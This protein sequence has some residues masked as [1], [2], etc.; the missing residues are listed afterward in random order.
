MKKMKNVI[1]PTI[2]GLLLKYIERLYLPKK[3]QAIFNLSFACFE[4]S[5]FRN[6]VIGLKVGSVRLY[7][8]FSLLVLYIVIDSA[9]SLT[10][11]YHVDFSINLYNS[12]G[13]S[14]PYYQKGK[15]NFMKKEILTPSFDFSSSFEH[16]LTMVLSHDKEK[17]ISPDHLR[18]VVLLYTLVR[19]LGYVTDTFEHDYESL[20]TFLNVVEGKLHLHKRKGFVN[21]ELMESNEVFNI[22]RSLFISK[23][24]IFRDF[25]EGP[26]IYFELE[27]FHNCI[28]LLLILELELFIKRLDNEIELI[29]DE[30]KM[31]KVMARK[32]I[33]KNR[34]GKLLSM[35]SPGVR[36][37]LSKKRVRIQSSLFLGFDTEFK[38]RN[39]SF[40]ELLAYSTAS[41]VRTSLEI[42]DFMVNYVTTNSKY[43]NRS[44]L[45]NKE[46]ESLILI[47]R[48]IRGREDFKVPQLISNLKEKGVSYKKLQGKLVFN[49][50]N[51][52][53]EDIKT[54]FKDLRNAEYK[55]AEMLDNSIGAQ[56]VEMLGEI[57]FFHDILSLS[58]FS[59]RQFLVKR[60]CFLIAHFNVADIASALD[61]E[62]FK[63]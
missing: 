7:S 2:R 47:I 48:F 60:E 29:N 46:M 42:S 63:P 32:I 5:N 11:D 40:N 27:H 35:V 38:V 26:D 37:C 31:E 17:M 18:R 36:S 54:L 59:K 22:F 8:I 53:I 62:M 33:L 39:D 12:I 61:F 23:S 41:L 13:L 55:L 43:T 49:R 4:L 45:V 50:Y 16:L 6:S 25:S 58:D 21:W 51:P 9:G 34:K 3:Y 1:S 52:R 24:E 14:L 20:T 56:E 30:V 10:L 28:L 57:D 44:P 19:R 15:V